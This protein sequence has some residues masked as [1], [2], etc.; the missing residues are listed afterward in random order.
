MGNIKRVHLVL[1]G[2][3]SS[4]TADSYQL[5]DFDQLKWAW[6]Y[7][8]D[9]IRGEG[10]ARR[11]ISSKPLMMSIQGCCETTFAKKIHEWPAWISS[12]LI[13]YKTLCNLFSAFYLL[14]IYCGTFMQYE[15]YVEWLKHPSFFSFVKS[16]DST[17]T[18]LL[19]SVLY[20]NSVSVVPGMCQAVNIGRKW[21]V[22]ES[23]QYRNRRSIK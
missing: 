4:A 14:D 23:G 16:S 21:T 1:S 8:I 17:V 3:F 12:E 5:V 18:L 10:D 19:Y 11:G 22:K 7:G 2:Q 9:L 20:V 15:K 6:M 13:H